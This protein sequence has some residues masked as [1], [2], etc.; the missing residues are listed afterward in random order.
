[1]HLADSARKEKVGIPEIFHGAILYMSCDGP[2]GSI[3]SNMLSPQ[4]CENLASQKLL[5]KSPQH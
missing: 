3:K 1:M 5:K 2:V 4:V